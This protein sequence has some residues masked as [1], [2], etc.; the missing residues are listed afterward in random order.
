MYYVIN[1]GHRYCLKEIFKTEITQKQDTVNK[2]PI[3]IFWQRQ[4]ANF[5]GKN[6]KLTLIS[7]TQ[8]Y[9]IDS[10]SILAQ[11]LF[12]PTDQLL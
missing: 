4:Q 2:K 12:F 9:L 11:L 5:L 7:G 1:F 8:G 6:F 10:N 3:I